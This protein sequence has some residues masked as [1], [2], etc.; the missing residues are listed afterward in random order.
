MDLRS[1]FQVALS[2][3]KQI[4]KNYQELLEAQRA[5]KES[6]DYNSFLLEN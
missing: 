4:E 1:D 6:F 2:T 3:A 5:A